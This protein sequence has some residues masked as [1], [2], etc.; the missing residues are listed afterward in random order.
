MS[1]VRL[2]GLL[3]CETPEQAQAVEENLPLHIELTRA[4][5]GCLSFEVNRAADPFV[6]QVEERFQDA[7]AFAA[8]QQ[9]IADSEWG[10]TTAGIQRQYEVEGA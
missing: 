7:A 4:E 8:H 6:W 3:I 10:R 2:T 9:R 5:P 1:V